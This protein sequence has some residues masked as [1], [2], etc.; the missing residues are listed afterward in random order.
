MSVQVFINLGIAINGT[1]WVVPMLKLLAFQR[2]WS[3]D[4]HGSSIDQGWGE[5]GQSF[6]RNVSYVSSYHC[7]Q[8]I[9]GSVM[10]SIIVW[11]AITVILLISIQSSGELLHLFVKEELLTH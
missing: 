11:S 2:S 1:G 4:R 10:I 9:W 7:H 8:L 6:S 5:H 3:I